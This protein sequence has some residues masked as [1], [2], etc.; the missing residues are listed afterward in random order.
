MIL[1]G[2]KRSQGSQEEQGERLGKKDT[3]GNEDASKAQ[4]KL[5]VAG[6]LLLLDEIT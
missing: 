1:K 5:F 6:N 3:G 4:V 2:F